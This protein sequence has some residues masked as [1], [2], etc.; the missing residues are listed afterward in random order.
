VNEN[1]VILFFLKKNVTL[2]NLHEPSSCDRLMLVSWDVHMLHVAEI[3]VMKCERSGHLLPFPRR[4]FKR[5]KRNILQL[6]SI[7][8]N[9]V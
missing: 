2:E 4:V 5:I 8:T 6:K 7:V 1:S 3:R 9:V